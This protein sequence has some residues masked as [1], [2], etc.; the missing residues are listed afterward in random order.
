MRNSDKVD[1]NSMV[2]F[3][4]GRPSRLFRF[5]KLQNRDVARLTALKMVKRNPSIVHIQ[6]HVITG[7]YI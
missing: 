5:K 6:T 4:R 2:I 7:G 3:R 1:I